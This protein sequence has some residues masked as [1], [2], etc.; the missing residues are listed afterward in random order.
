MEQQATFQDKMR[1]LKETLTTTRRKEQSALSKEISKNCYRF[2]KQEDWFDYIKR[3]AHEC[4]RLYEYSESDFRYLLSTVW[5]L[6]SADQL[7]F[8][9]LLNVLCNAFPTYEDIVLEDAYDASL[10]N[11]MGKINDDFCYLLE[12]MVDYQDVEGVSC[13]SADVRADVEYIFECLTLDAPMFDIAWILE[14]RFNVSNEELDQLVEDRIRQLYDNEKIEKLFSEG[15]L[16]Q[17]FKYA[18]GYDMF[19]ECAPSLLWRD[20]HPEDQL[21]GEFGIRVLTQIKAN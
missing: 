9:P 14:N 5:T 16:V 2:K 18:K 11:G 20:S 15:A 8:K 1:A 10:H 3:I 17:L 19:L 13:F 21:E 4:P 6:V 12:A 7:S